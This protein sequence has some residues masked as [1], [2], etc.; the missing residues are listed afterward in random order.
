MDF[1]WGHRETAFF[2]EAI[3]SLRAGATGITSRKS[4]LDVMRPRS[5][6]R[7]WDVLLNGPPAHLVI[8][9]SHLSMIDARRDYHDAKVWNFDAHH[10]L[11]YGMKED[12]CGNW[13]RR[14][15]ELG[16]ISAYTLVY[17]KWR[18]AE[19]EA[20][21]PVPEGLDFECTYD[22][23]KIENI[24]MVFICR[25]GSWTPTWCD[26]EWLRFISY[27]KKW[28]WLWNMKLYSEMALRKRSP[29]MAEAAKLREDQTAMFAEMG[30]L[31]LTTLE[32]TPRD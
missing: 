28:P 16:H 18:L 9:E 1:D 19:P 25:S 2:N 29:N 5:H 8:A 32:G 7:F 11:G 17:P 10:D 13:A 23:P 27:F 15:F 30:V 21:L 24:D 3:W 22:V 4:A 20:E 31:P 6:R 14:A 26:T 12:N